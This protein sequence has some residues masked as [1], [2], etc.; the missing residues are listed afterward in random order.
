MRP[1]SCGPPGWGPP[2]YCNPDPQIYAA[3]AHLERGLLHAVLLAGPLLRHQLLG[4]TQHVKPGALP[5]PQLVAHTARGAAIKQA[6]VVKVAIKASMCSRVLWPTRS[7]SPMLQGGAI[8]QARVV[9]VA[10]M[11]SRYGR[12]LSPYRGWSPTLQRA[13]GAGSLACLALLSVQLI[14]R[15]HRTKTPDRC[16]LAL[17]A[18]YSA[19]TCSQTIPTAGRVCYCTCSPQRHVLAR[20][21]ALLVQVGAVSGSWVQQ[22]SGAIASTELNHGMQP[23]HM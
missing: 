4:A 22:E 1:A 8:K 5:K 7:W 20:R 12:M 13:E 15:P 6:R 21:Q 17:L 19:P 14:A 16:T 3:T 10:I 2:L 9:K 11:A 23:A 18:S